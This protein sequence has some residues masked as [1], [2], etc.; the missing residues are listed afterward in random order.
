MK[1]I[2]YII[3]GVM[4]LSCSKRQEYV[5]ALEQLQAQNKAFVPFTSDSL[6]KDVVNYFNRHGS[7]NEQMKAHYLLGCVYRDLGE[8]PHAIDCYLE[9]ISK[10]DTTAKDCDFSTLSSVY[11]QM[12]EIC[13]QQLLL[14]NAIEVQKKASHFALLA[15]QKYWSVYNQERV[16]GTYILMDKRDSAELLLKNLLLTIQKNLWLKID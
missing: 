15:N 3:I 7:R 5:N 6:A 13:H 8:A 9:A 1:Q 12:A 14:S 16:A 4:F 10:A 11:S 2:L